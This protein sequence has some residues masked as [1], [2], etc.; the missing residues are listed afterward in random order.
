MDSPGVA[1]CTRQTDSR[2]SC[3]TDGIPK[4]G[5]PLPFANVSRRPLRSSPQSSS[6]T[7]G[8]TLCTPYCCT[9]WCR[10]TGVTGRGY[11]S[12]IDGGGIGGSRW[13]DE[14]RLQ[15]RNSNISICLHD[16]KST[17][18]VE[19]GLL[20]RR[21]VSGISTINRCIT[22]NLYKYNLENK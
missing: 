10:S 21:R 7:C 12:D 9:R 2:G 5:R 8:R 4:C 13:R 20:T 19:T 3:R 18:S 1:S 22:R 11:L 17:R 14:G 15:G 6:R 16:S